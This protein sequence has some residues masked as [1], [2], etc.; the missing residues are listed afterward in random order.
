MGY[1]NANQH[2]YGLECATNM[3]GSIFKMH[4]KWHFPWL[5]GQ[6]YGAKIIRLILK[7]EFLLT[8]LQMNFKFSKFFHMFFYYLLHFPK[9]KQHC[10]QLITGQI[11]VAPPSS[12]CT[13]AHQACLSDTTG[14]CIFAAASSGALCIQL[15]SV[16]GH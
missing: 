3:S 16:W 7:M 2:S 10:F 12:S 6:E 4:D 1:Q 15:C 9:E 5:K 14:K 13:V 11:T 8:I